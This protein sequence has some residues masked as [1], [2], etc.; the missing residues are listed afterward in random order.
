[1]AQENSRE[2]VKSEKRSKGPFFGVRHVFVILGK[3]RTKS[4]R[5]SRK[6]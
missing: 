4:Y 3:K 2:E 5:M 6:K 1:M